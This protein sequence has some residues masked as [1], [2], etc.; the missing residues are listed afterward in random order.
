MLCCLNVLLASCRTV[1][2]QPLAALLL[3]PPPALLSQPVR[4]RPQLRQRSP[5]RPLWDVQQVGWQPVAVAAVA[6]AVASAGHILPGAG[7]LRSCQLGVEGIG[8]R[9]DEVW[10]ADWLW[11][12]QA[13]CCAQ[14]AQRCRHLSC[15]RFARQMRRLSSS[16]QRTAVSQGPACQAVLLAIQNTVPQARQLRRPPGCQRPLPRLRQ[17]HQRRCGLS[18][19]QQLATLM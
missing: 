9:L 18:H 15:P 8:A 11:L 19:T 5:P 4:P 17:Q 3:L 13:D 2:A 7:A 16:C 14:G 10:H 12:F 1:K 6:S